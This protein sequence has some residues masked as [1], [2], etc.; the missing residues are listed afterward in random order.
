MNRR[1]FLKR[2]F[3]TVV[4]AVT[5]PSRPC[6][7]EN[8]P[9]ARLISGWPDLTSNS[10]AHHAVFLCANR[11]CSRR[12]QRIPIAKLE[13]WIPVFDPN[14]SDRTLVHPV[15]VNG[16]KKEEDESRLDLPTG[17]V[18]AECGWKHYYGW[19]EVYGDRHFTNLIEVHAPNSHVPMVKS[20]GWVKQAR[21]CSDGKRCFTRIDVRNKEYRNL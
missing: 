15:A 16:T 14:C 6:P 12:L 7:A 3:G 13:R 5:V 9:S 8:F 2:C 1:G 20:I 11:M 4:A 19:D 21:Y 18:C 17:F 10:K